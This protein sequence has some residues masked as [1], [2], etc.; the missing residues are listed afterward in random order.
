MKNSY[1]WI[2]FILAGLLIGCDRN[3]SQ[4]QAA[5]KKELMLYCGAGI[6][7]PVAELAQI[8]SREHGV[9]VVTDY[10][11]CEVLISKI[12]LR[13]QG[14]LYMPG[15]KYYVDQAAAKGMILAQKVVCYFVP[16]IMVQKG[17]PRNIQTLSDLTKP[18]IK[19]GLGDERAC[20]IGRISQKIFEKNH[21][22]P[23]ALEKNL[24]F[25]SL[26]V[27]ELGLQIEAG[28]LDAVIVWDAIAQYY[29][30]TA[31]QIPIPPAQNVI[32]TVDIA[33]LRFTE[34]QEL[35]KKFVDFVCSEPGRAVF[36]KHHYC[37]DPPD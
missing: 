14:D 26:T 34:N 33:I 28:S 6:R 24:A 16:V 37:V 35:A 29:P 13:R 21:I 8:F 18:G 31:Q 10:A 19:L 15:D 30:E 7:P 22:P 11:G 3:S 23:S 36:K 17:N 9:K 5:G 4:R 32:S 20:A 12:T 27:N 1:V 2:A 25:R